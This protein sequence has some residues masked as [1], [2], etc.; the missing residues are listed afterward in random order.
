MGKILLIILALLISNNSY[1]TLI[2]Y[3]TTYAPQGQVTSTN[4]NG[5][6]NNASSVV[7]GKL[8]NTNADTTNGYRFFQTVANLPSTG[9]QG[10]VY[11]LTSDNSLNFDTGSSFAKSVSTPTP[12]SGNVPYYTSSWGLLSVGTAAN[13][14]VQLDSSDKLPA[15]DG[16]QL[17][18]IAL[19]FVKVITASPSAVGSFTISGLTSGTNYVLYM[20][21]VQNTSNGT[22]SFQFNGDSGSNYSYGTIAAFTGGANTV[23]SNSDTKILPM[24][25]DVKSGTSFILNS[26]FDTAPSVNSTVLLTSQ[27]FSQASSSNF[28][29]GSGGGKYV[30]GSTLSS[31][32]ISTSAGTLTG[33]AVLYKIL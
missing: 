13:N 7:N 14:I 18:N 6:F 19:Q 33:N 16:S 1:A 23:A 31:I 3:G 28:L 25:G 20:Q 11:F 12:S 5:N 21:L 30:G 2:T 27:S 8:D 22:I 17:T 4:L 29:G 9:S 24:T 26:S 32:T 15:V 10:A